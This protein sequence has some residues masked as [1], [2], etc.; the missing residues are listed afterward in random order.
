VV[1]TTG[2]SQGPLQG[3]LETHRALVYLEAPIVHVNLLLPQD[4]VFLLSK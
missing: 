3:I 2:T 4:A 1:V